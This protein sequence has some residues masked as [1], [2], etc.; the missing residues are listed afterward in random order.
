MKRKIVSR[1]DLGSDR[2]A[3][4]D[5]YTVCVNF[6]VQLFKIQVGSKNLSKKNER[7]EE[8]FGNRLTELLLSDL[9]S[10]EESGQKRKR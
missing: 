10:N 3:V 1:A 9:G 6:L 7:I 5:P 8:A 4:G 2:L